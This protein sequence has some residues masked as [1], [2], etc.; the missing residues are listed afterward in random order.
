[1][2]MINLEIL[3]AAKNA[4]DPQKEAAMGLIMILNIVQ[5]IFSQAA[6]TALG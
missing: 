2:V 6:V 1:M 5:T 3:Q 4:R